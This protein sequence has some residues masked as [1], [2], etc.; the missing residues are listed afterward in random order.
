VVQQSADG[1][2][3]VFH[4]DGDGRLLA[5]PE[6]YRHVMY[7]PSSPAAPAAKKAAPPM[8]AYG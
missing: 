3:Q 5:A 7:K 1:T 6:C 4:Y 2:P 8:L